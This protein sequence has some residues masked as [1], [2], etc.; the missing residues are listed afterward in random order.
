MELT[1]EIIVIGKWYISKIFKDLGDF[2]ALE[3]AENDKLKKHLKN[4]IKDK[5]PNFLRS[6][7][8]DRLFIAR[9]K[10]MFN[11]VSF[12]C[13]NC[14]FETNVPFSRLDS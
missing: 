12:I 10:T 5:K 6:Q 1:K 4:F 8:C 14:K 11:E 2:T 9:F 13:N 3:K 7:A